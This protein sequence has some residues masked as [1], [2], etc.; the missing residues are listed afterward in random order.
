M[1]KSKNNNVKSM[2]CNIPKSQEAPYIV[3]LNLNTLSRSYMSKASPLGYPACCI[4]SFRFLSRN[5]QKRSGKR[6]F[7]A[8]DGILSWAREPPPQP[9]HSLVADLSHN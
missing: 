9:C 7:G 5:V 2:S 3:R 1:Q 6:A 8:P 4:S